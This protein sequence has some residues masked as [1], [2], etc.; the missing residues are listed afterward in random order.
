MTGITLTNAGSAYT[1]YTVSVEKPLKLIKQNVL[2]T[3]GISM[4]LATD[5]IVTYTQLIQPSVAA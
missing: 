4:A 3:S 5:L 2:S 1:T